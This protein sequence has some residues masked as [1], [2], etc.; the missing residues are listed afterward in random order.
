MA[1]TD[2]ATSIAPAVDAREQVRERRMGRRAWAMIGMVV[3]FAILIAYALASYLP[4]Y[5]MVVT[6]LKANNAL[7]KVPPEWLP[8]PF[9][10]NSYTRLLSFPNTGRWFL[11][12][13][14]VVGSI[15]L[16]RLLFA[17]LAGYVFAKF[18]F[19]G[20]NLLFWAILITLMIPEQVILI[21]LYSLMVNWDWLNTFQGLILP[22]LG[23]AYYTF[24]M[25]QY[26]QSLPSSLID[27]ARIDAA[28]EL[29]IFFKIIVPL[30]LP[31]LAVMGV[32]SFVNSWNAFIWPLLMGSRQD[33]FTIQVGLVWLRYGPLDWGMLMAGASAAAVPVIIIFLLFQRYV[34]RGLTVGAIKT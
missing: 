6:S 10:L 16:G 28:S 34:V 32:F 13:F 14:V 15:T 1:V 19:P 31:G 22:P 5:W 7:L 21:P 8:N 30:S 9:T 27:A 11:N 3:V 23:T 2:R 33:M 18:R 26:M 12:S 24:L 17:S 25:K 4:I 20:R 29:G